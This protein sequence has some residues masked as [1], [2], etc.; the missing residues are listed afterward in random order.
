MGISRDGKGSRGWVGCVIGAG[1]DAA[2]VSLLGFP[3]TGPG[4]STGGTRA[5]PGVQEDSASESMIPSRNPLGSGNCDFLQENP[6]FRVTR[7]LHSPEVES[8]RF[9]IPALLNG[10]RGLF[11]GFLWIRDSRVAT[12]HESQHGPP[13][14][15]KS[16]ETIPSFPLPGLVATLALLSGGAAFPWDLRISPA[17]EIQYETQ[18]GKAYLL[19]GAS[20]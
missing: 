7:S 5:G 16:Y 17:I 6:D 3:R 10:V 20:T 12:K 18:V 13:M 1:L 19:Q 8:Q 15:P 9:G 14:I 11:S 2:I 4:R